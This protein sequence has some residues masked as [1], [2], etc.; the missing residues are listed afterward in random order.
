MKKLL[1]LTLVIVLMFTLCPLAVLADAGADGETATEANTIDA[2]AAVPDESGASSGTFSGSVLIAY[3]TSTA[4]ESQVSGSFSGTYTASSSSVMTKSARRENVYDERTDE[5]TGKTY[6]LTEPDLP[7]Y[8]PSTQSKG[9]MRSASAAPAAS[10]AVNTERSFLDD[11]NNNRSMKCLYVGS[12]CTVWGCTSDPGAIDINA[13]QAASIGQYYDGKYAAMTSAFG[14]YHYDVDGD[15]KVAIMCYDIDKNFETNPNVNSYT[16]GF[17]WSYDMYSEHNGLDCIHIDTFPGMGGNASTPLTDV[18]GCY[19]TLFHEFQHMIN[20][21]YQVKNNYAYGEMET[22]LN[23]AFSMAAEHLICGTDSVSTRVSFFNNYSSQYSGNPLTY[24]MGDGYANLYNYSTSYLFGQYVR[25][26]YAQVQGGDGSTIFKKVLE[27]RSSANDGDTLGIICNLLGTSAGQLVAD[28]WRAV[29]L[30]SASGPFGFNGETWA[31]NISP[32]VYSASQLSSLN[33]GIYNSGC[34]YFNI[35]GGSYTVSSSSNMAF[36]RPSMQTPAYAAPTNLT[37][38]YGNTL[39]SVNINGGNGSGSGT[40]SWE[41]PSTAVNSSGSYTAVFTPSDTTHYENATVAV[42]VSLSSAQSAA[43]RM[44]PNMFVDWQ[45]TNGS[46]DAMAVDWYCQQ[47]AN[48]TYWAVHNWYKGYAGFQNKD[49]KHMLLMSLWDLDDG[50]KPTVEYAKDGSNGDFGG[51][52]A[53]KQVFTNYAWQASQWY[54][55]LVSCWTANG[56]TYVGQWVRQGTGAWVKTAVISYPVTGLNLFN[57]DSTFQEDFTFNNLQRSCRLKNAYGRIAGTNTWESWNAGNIRSSYYPTAQTIDP[58]WDI[59]FDCNRN[60][61]GSYIWVQS[62]GGDANSI[63]NSLPFVANVSQ[64]A[65]PS[66]PDWM[67]GT[68]YKANVVYNANGGTGAPAGVTVKIDSAGVAR[69]TLS[70]TTPKR[71]GYTFLGWRLEN[72][73]EHYQIDHPGQSITIQLS[74]ERDW[75]LTYYAQWAFAGTKASS[76]SLNYSYYELAPGKSLSLKATTD[77]V[78]TTEKVLWSSSNPDITVSTSGRVTVSAGAQ[79]NETAVITAATSVTGKKASC[80]IK[81]IIPTS[82]LVIT[83][84]AG[85]RLSKATI[86]YNGAPETRSVQLYARATEGHT[87]SL[88]WSSNEGSSGNLVSY[89]YHSIASGGSLCTVTSTGNGGG[90]VTMTVRSG[91]GKSARCTVTIGGAADSLNVTESRYV[92]AS[93]GN[94]S[95]DVTAT[96]GRSLTLKAVPVCRDGVTRPIDKNVVWSIQSITDSG[97]NPTREDPADYITVSAKGAVKGLQPCHA[98]IRAAAEAGSAD[99]KPVTFYVTVY[100]VLKSVSF[101]QDGTRLSKLTVSPGTALSLSEYLSIVWGDY[102]SHDDYC[103]VSYQLVSGT[104]LDVN[105]NGT[106]TVEP[107]A[108]GTARI[109][110]TVTSGTQVKTATLTLTIG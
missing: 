49:G 26:R 52:G 1:S 72:D 5:N 71:T 10:Y 67:E 25:T 109:K 90:R 107:G 85:A 7:V 54:T 69:Y 14:T 30:K 95:Y 17:F 28:F 34:R 48:N 103:G 102:G 88:T 94:L 4:T 20:Y 84:E 61:G 6:Y 21:S 36:E 74:T 101:A 64:A 9:L 38:V 93:G 70:N 82:S 46:Y 35:S 66:Y 39:S 3:N 86:T 92:V 106:V 33:T 24:W 47:D 15:G 40:W 32:Y 53:G 60:S 87:D 13:T 31:N 56:K 43:V 55:M 104:G 37:A 11:S 96:A 76:L 16:G 79:A 65:A 41:S 81:V 51:E 105:D 68:A 77:P 63:G 23:E 50:T 2:G 91:S 99:C 18:S 73:A 62:G 29:Y 108:A 100:P 57:K 80:T 22:Y 19:S 27:S 42:P 75:T 78:R 83:D 98:I 58:Q 97:W 8:I 45:V 110:V 44:A 12:Y 59:N 89:E